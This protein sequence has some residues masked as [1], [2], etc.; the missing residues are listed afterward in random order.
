ERWNALTDARLEQYSAHRLLLGLRWRRGPVAFAFGYERVR[1]AGLTPPSFDDLETAEFAGDGTQSYTVKESAVLFGPVFA[2]DTSVCE[3]AGTLCG[4]WWR[5][6]S[7]A[8]R[9]L[10]LGQV[11]FVDRRRIPEELVRFRDPE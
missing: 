7:L 10:L 9:A 2:G 1:R 3:L 4:L 11:A 8:G 6:F 5:R